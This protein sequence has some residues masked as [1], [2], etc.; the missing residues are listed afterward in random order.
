MV[1]FSQETKVFIF[2]AGGLVFHA[3]LLWLLVSKTKKD[4]L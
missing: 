4:F 1:C 3:A 2:A